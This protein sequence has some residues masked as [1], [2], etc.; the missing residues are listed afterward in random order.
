MA[1]TCGFSILR[2]EDGRGYM[3]QR[4]ELGSPNKHVSWRR[5]MAGKE[6]AISLSFDVPAEVEENFALDI[7]RG[8]R[9]RSTSYAGNSRL[10][11]VTSHYTAMAVLAAPDKTATQSSL[12][13][14]MG[15]SPNVAVALVGYLDRLGYTRR[16]QNPRDRREDIVLLTKRRRKVYD[17]AVRSLW[18]VE[19]ELLAPLLVE[20]RE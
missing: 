1:R 17:Q 19:E 2:M 15:I 4:D 3:I 10:K 5:V 13:K 7:W 20:E 9:G 14:S 12:V 8:L 18:Q 16:V 11:I 6:H